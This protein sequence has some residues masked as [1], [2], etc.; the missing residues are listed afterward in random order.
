VGQASVANERTDA[1]DEYAKARRTYVSAV[2]AIAGG[3]AIAGTVDRSFGGAV[4]L[5]GW[6]MCVWALHR[7]GRAGAGD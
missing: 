6:V 7:L 5:A 4:V 2:V 3:L 1:E